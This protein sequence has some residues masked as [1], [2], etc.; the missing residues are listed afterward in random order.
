MKKKKT[1]KIHTHIKVSEKTQRRYCQKV[2]THR[3][4]LVIKSQK[5]KLSKKKKKKKRVQPLVLGE[6]KFWAL[7]AE[8]Y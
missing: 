3:R 2:L 1:R 6:V 8:R 5:V 4:L 7:H